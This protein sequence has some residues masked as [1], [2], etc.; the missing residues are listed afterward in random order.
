EVFFLRRDEKRRLSQKQKR[1]KRPPGVEVTWLRGKDLKLPPACGRRCLLPG[2]CLWW[3]TR[4]FAARV[5]I[6]LRLQ[7]KQNAESFLP[8]VKQLGCGAGIVRRQRRRSL[9]P[10][11]WLWWS[12][13]T[14]G[15]NPSG[16]Q[17]CQPETETPEGF[18]RRPGILVAGEGFEPSTFGL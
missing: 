8:A 14:R 13:Q 9:L 16:G 18:S 15:S 2:A 11:V 3:S 4:G 12:T 7:R 1:R 17:R 10:G 6:P 5:Q